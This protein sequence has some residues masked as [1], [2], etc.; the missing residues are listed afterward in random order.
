M[1]SISTEMKKFIEVAA[2]KW[3]TLAWKDKA[4]GAFTNS[5]SFSGDKPN[6]LLGLVVNAM[7]HSFISVSLGL[8]PSAN[9]PEGMTRVR[10]PIIASV[11]LPGRCR[12]AFN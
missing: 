6:S 1:G 11:R 5:S 3:F 10:T 12:P 8:M 2:K 9:Q 4:V 7:Q